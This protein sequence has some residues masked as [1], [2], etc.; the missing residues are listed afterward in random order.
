MARVHVG[1]DAL[2]LRG[3]QLPSLLGPLRDPAVGGPAWDKKV[4]QGRITY[5]ARDAVTSA[6]IEDWRFKTFLPDF[7]AAYK[8]EWVPVDFK[9]QDQWCLTKAYLTVFK[10]N[11]STRDL[12][13]FICLHCDPEEPD[14]DPKSRYKQGP[15]LHIKAAVAPIPKAHVALAH[16][17][18]KMILGS[19]KE[20]FH[21]MRL[22][23]ELIRDEI[24]ART[25]EE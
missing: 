17:Y 13:E 11:R 23:I 16:G 20:L 4:G 22:A 3:S 24:L 8:E 19:D 9:K 6:T 14:A 1:A 5:V 18:L 21:A 10:L 2:S 25:S 12:T 7:Y 15:H